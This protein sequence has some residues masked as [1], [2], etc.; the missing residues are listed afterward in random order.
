MN[1]SSNRQVRICDDVGDHRS[2]GHKNDAL[3]SLQCSSL[4]PRVTEYSTRKGQALWSRRSTKNGELDGRRA[5]FEDSMYATRAKTELS[6]SKPNIGTLAQDE[7]CHTA[8]KQ[9][10]AGDHSEMSPKSKRIMALTSIV[11]SALVRS[12]TMGWMLPT[13]TS[14]P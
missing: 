12:F 7:I 3:S 1:G 13:D 14:Q 11:D 10:K 4:P 5:D 8:A 2:K 6:D 9:S